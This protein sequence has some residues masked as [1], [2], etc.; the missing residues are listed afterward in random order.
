MAPNA[1]TEAADLRVIAALR[2]V[3]KKIDQVRVEIDEE[4]RQRRKA[5]CRLWWAMCLSVVA[6]VGVLLAV[7]GL[8]RTAARVEREAVDRS[9]ALCKEA[10]LTRTNVGDVLSQLL[11]L[12]EPADGELPAV[13]RAAAEERRARARA[14]GEAA[15]APKDCGALP[16]TEPK[17]NP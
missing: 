12:G 7:V 9:V 5:N 8:V 2:A 6:G 14:L 11:D 17:E 1:D 10:N 13:R 16:G 3:G 15:F 4:R